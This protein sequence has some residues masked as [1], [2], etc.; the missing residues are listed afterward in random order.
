MEVR[1]N[2]FQK[3]N[4]TKTK[5]PICKKEGEASITSSGSSCQDS[6]KEISFIQ[7][8]KGQQEGPKAVPPPRASPALL[9][10]LPAK[11][12]QHPGTRP[13]SPSTTIEVQ[14][15]EGGEGLPFP[16]TTPA[17]ACP[18]PSPAGHETQN[19]SAHSMI[20]LPR[21]QGATGWPE[22]QRGRG[23]HH[24]GSQQPHARSPRGTSWGKT[25]PESYLT[26]GLG[27][28]SGGCRRNGVSTLS[29]R[30]RRQGRWEQGGMLLVL[31]APG[32][33][34]VSGGTV[35]RLRPFFL[36][37]RHEPFAREKPRRTQHGLDSRFRSLQTAPGEPSSALALSRSPLVQVP[38][39]LNILLLL[40]ASSFAS[41]N[42]E[43]SALT[44]PLQPR[45][46]PSALLVPQNVPPAPGCRGE[47][48]V[49][50]AMRQQRLHHPPPSPNPGPLPRT[51]PLPAPPAARTVHESQVTRRPP[52]RDGGGWR[53]EALPPLVGG[54]HSDG[55]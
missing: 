49:R 16:Q 52:P 30:V 20:Q 38:A 1:T 39:P 19:A 37:P 17:P 35:E 21:R 42:P 9:E 31:H 5:P 44:L 33:M 15:G 32:E 11:V 22:D 53:Q 45:G 55:G 28:R 4:Q 34:C 26:Q 23:S 3:K 25:L 14:Q 50:V 41:E 40:C 18:W 51:H 47:Q 29:P 43:S 54:G 6:A 2:L 24:H 46:H 48:S 8:R 10:L 7:Q 27:L 36:C 13:S 12:H